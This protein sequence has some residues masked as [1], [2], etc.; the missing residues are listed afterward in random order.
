MSEG[1]VYHAGNEEEPETIENLENDQESIEEVVRRERSDNLKGMK[2]STV[3]DPVDSRK[4]T[5]K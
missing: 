2:D 5:F 1:P 3:D 4:F